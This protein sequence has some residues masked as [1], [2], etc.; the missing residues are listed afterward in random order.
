MKKI[1]AIW[2][3]WIEKSYFLNK[4]CIIRILLSPYVCMTYVLRSNVKGIR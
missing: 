4:D 2:K 1:A 3:K